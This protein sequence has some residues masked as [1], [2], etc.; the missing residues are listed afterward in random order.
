[1]DA[2]LPRSTVAMLESR[3]HAA[4]H[5]H[6]VG[7]G[8]APDSQIAARALAGQAVLVTRDLDFADIRNYPPEQRGG[9]IVLR[10]PD[11]MIARDILSLLGRF[12]QEAELVAQVP[13]HLCILEPA[14][15]R[16][17]PALT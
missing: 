12:L 15:V 4:E 13:R 7:L 10:A 14:R 2:N 16:F 5:A 6:E 9:I 8:G 1:M 11:D 3:G 17:R